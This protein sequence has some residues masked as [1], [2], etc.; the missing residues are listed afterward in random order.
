MKPRRTSAVMWARRISRIGVLGFGVTFSPASGPAPVAASQSTPTV[1]TSQGL[2]TLGPGRITRE[3]GLRAIRDQV[4]LRISWSAHRALSDSVDVQVSGVPALAAV[5]AV[6][7]GSPLEVQMTRSG[8][9][10]VRPARTG[11]VRG[12]VTSE[13]M[14]EPLSDAVVELVGTQWST[15]TDEEGRYTLAEIP[16]GDYQLSVYLIGFGEA[17]RDVRVV[18]GETV[19]MDIALSTDAVSLAGVSVVA[20]TRVQQEMREVRQSPFSVSVIDGQRL[21]SRGLTL[22]EALQRATGIQVR[23]SGGLGSASIFHVRGLEGNRVRIYIDGNPVSGTGDSFT[24]DDIPLALVERVEVYKGVVP[25]R[26]GGDGL[27]AAVNVV[28]REFPGG[29]DDVSYAAGSFGQHQIA[30]L[31][32]RRPHP[33]FEVGFS[34][35]L[36][37]ADNDYQMESPFI[38]G[39]QITRD[40]DRFRRAVV[41]GTLNYTGGWFDDLHVEAAGI[42][43]RR[44]IQGIQTNVQH[45]EASSDFGVLL[46]HGDR[47]GAMGGRLD[48]TLGLVALA[49]RAALVDTSSVRYTFGGDSFPSPNGRGELAALPSHSDNTRLLFRQRGTATYRFS[50][51]HTGNLTYVFDHSR[52]EP[53]DT[54]A[55][56]FAGRNV[57]E[58]PGQQTNVVVGASHEWR[59]MGERFVNVFGVRAYAF[60]S[61][62]TPQNLFDV[63]GERPPEITNRTFSLGVSEAARY[64]LTPELLAKGSIVFAT[65]LPESTELFGDGLLLQPAPALEPERTINLNVGL[66]FE[67]GRP[68]DGHLQAEVN[69]FA[70]WLRDMIQLAAGGFGG[71]A[72]HANVGEARIVGF[73]VEMKGDVTPWLY[74]TGGFT[75]QD[76]RDVRDFI[77]GSSVPSPTRGLR[78]P[79]LPWLFGTFA[80][81]A[82]AGD[83]LGRNQQ[84][85]VFLETSFTDEYFFAFEMSR[86]QERRIPRAL[87]H[88]LG[89]EH[90]WLGSGITLTAEIQNIADAEVLNQFRQP[91]PGRM[92]RLKL[93]YTRIRD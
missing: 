6:L 39:L 72:A 59:P 33:D 81:E 24:L 4:G 35:N 8:V 30:S 83:L 78:L 16:P 2:V 60:H 92:F 64:F 87:T 44:E 36:D 20:E 31:F 7:E 54:L 52:F 80:L 9:A 21:A 84:S 65:R 79:N 41:G 23:R 88:T 73:D 28:I 90:Q 37:L 75:Y 17:A 56:R 70:M 10:A 58:F 57:S 34:A 26:F 55:N 47:Q 42:L 46:M 18:S 61:E 1:Q 67:R 71:T 63:T 25:A 45:A 27:G 48:V 91:L 14:G 53:R 66:Q 68:G 51:A 62:G 11:T 32:V 19:E 89:F 85:R 29:Y 93:R 15:L 77:P 5:R 13:S 22:D 12:V 76:A 49:T 74:A 82:H 86:N 43:S 3:E 50:P 38:P 69:G 40:H